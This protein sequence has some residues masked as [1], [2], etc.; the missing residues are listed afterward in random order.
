MKNSKPTIYDPAFLPNNIYSGV[1]S[2]LNLPVL[3]NESELSSM[4]AVVTGVPWE[5][6]CTIGGYSSCTEGPKAIRSVSIR[7]TGYLPDFDLDAFDY[8]KVG[9]FGDVAC[10]NGDYPLTF[11]AIRERIS[12]IDQLSVSILINNSVQKNLKEINYQTLVIQSGSAFSILMPILTIPPTLVMMNMPAAL[13]SISFTMIRI[14]IP[15]R[16]FTSVS[17]DRVTIKRNLQMQKN[18]VQL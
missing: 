4:D 13:R 7:Y 15:Q 6:G 16:S 8:L 5:G 14:W 3:E 12:Q 17:A 9:D 2:W 1:P 10:R 18:T 11:A